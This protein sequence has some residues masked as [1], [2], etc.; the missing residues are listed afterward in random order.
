[1]KLLNPLSLSNKKFR[2]DFLEDSLHLRYRN[3]CLEEKNIPGLC[4]YHINTDGTLQ[5]PPLSQHC[6]YNHGANCRCQSMIL[7]VGQDEKIWFCETYKNK[8]WSFNGRMK[9]PKKSKG[10]GVMTSCF[11]DPIRGMGIQLHPNELN[12]VNEYRSQ[13]NRLP[14]LESPGI[15]FFRYGKNREGYWNYETFYAQV[16]DVLDVYEALFPQYQIALEIDQSSG[17]LKYED[18]SLQATNLNAKW[19]GSQSVMRDSKIA[20]ES[21]LGPNFKLLRVGDIQKMQFDESSKGPFYDPDREI[22]KYDRQYS[23]AEIAEHQRKKLKSSLPEIK[24]GWIGQPKGLMQILWERGWY[25]KDMSKSQMQEKLS[26]LPDFHDEK[27]GIRQLV[28]SRGHILIVSPVC[29][30]ECAG[31]GIEYCWSIA[32]VHFR[33]ILGKSAKNIEGHIRKVLGNQVL[34]I[35][36][37]WKYERHAREYLRLYQKADKDNPHL[38]YD[39]IEKLRNLEKTQRKHRSVMITDSQFVM[40]S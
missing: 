30:P 23:D 26:S 28:E 8:Y 24:K 11:V 29:H 15:V 20:N 9:P 5:T 6:K 33:N 25:E 38:S 40:T 27:C 18:D 2:I 36:R 19:G 39:E 22:N 3:Q 12:K 14:L 21:Y 13:Y 1:M 31:N 34:T 37:I 7:K 10:Y 32:D 4:F 35:E 17:H 16:N